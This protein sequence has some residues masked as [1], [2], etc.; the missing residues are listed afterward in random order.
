MFYPPCLPGPSRK[1][2]RLA[3]LYSRGAAWQD[4]SSKINILEYKLN[5]TL[6]EFEHLV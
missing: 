1:A 3:W 5:L 2:R 4:E 6:L